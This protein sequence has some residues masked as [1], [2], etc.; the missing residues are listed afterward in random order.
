MAR[1]IMALTLREMS[2]RYGRS[3]GGYIWAIL[4]PLGGIFVMALGFSLLVRSPP[5]GTSFL[6]FY[7]SG[8][9]AFNLYQGIS[10][11]VARAIAFSKQL[12]SYPAVSWL[13]AILARFILNSLTGIM[14]GYITIVSILVITGE[15]PNLDVGPLIEGLLLTLLLGLSVGTLNCALMGVISVWDQIWSI[16]TRPLFII[17]GVFFLYDTLPQT[18]QDILWF[19]PLLHIVGLMHMG[20]YPTYH[21]VHI[22]PLYVI[23]VSLGM[24]FL[25][26]VLLGR[27][28]RDILNR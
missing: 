16:A 2:S 20:F 8:F 15:R 4:E 9:T 10:N 11:T 19:N 27:Y 22:S 17:S 6:L 26:L 12:L 1:V 14:V 25:G 13:D 28:H 23:M 3:P 21:P 24:L 18:I 5:L 7:A